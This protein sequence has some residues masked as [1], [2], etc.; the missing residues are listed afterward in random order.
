MKFGMATHTLISPS[1]AHHITKRILTL[2]ELFKITSG[3]S[4]LYID[5]T[6][7]Y[8]KKLLKTANDK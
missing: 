1:Q 3:R 2:E 4:R 5:N 8:Y 6:I 7:D